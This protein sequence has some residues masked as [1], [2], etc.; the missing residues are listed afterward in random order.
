MA[1]Q[2][3]DL[4]MDE[5]KPPE[6]PRREYNFK[7]GASGNPKGRRSI[8]ER[9]QA[10]EAARKA[11]VAQLLAD[12]GRPPSAI[13]EALIDEIAGLRVQAAK[14]RKQ[15]KPTDRIA[16][17]ISRA[18]T[19]MV[20][21]ASTFRPPVTAPAAPAEAAAEEPTTIVEQLTPD[22]QKLHDQWIEESCAALDASL[23][24]SRREY[25]RPQPFERAAEDTAAV[26]VIDEHFRRKF[27]DAD[28]DKM[29]ELAR[30]KREAVER[31]KREEAAIGRARR[32]AGE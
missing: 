27:G 25:R 9:A 2:L 14:L 21:A 8:A 1:F 6:A 29:A 20:N 13:E 7:P 4:G 10:D 5:Q 26:E 18:A 28:E 17:L 24:R 16:M 11:F 19:A 32:A 30:Q 15:G 22:Q 23:E 12:L 31:Y 3:E